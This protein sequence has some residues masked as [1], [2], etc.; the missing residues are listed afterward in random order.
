MIKY[1]LNNTEIDVG[2]YVIL[3]G[4]GAN[5]VYEVLSL[6]KYPDNFILKVVFP[7]KLAKSLKEKN[8]FSMKVPSYNIELIGNPKKQPQ[9]R[10]LYG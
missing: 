5:T 4:A 3:K 6:E 9:L 1:L 7:K 8:V 10:V 2:D